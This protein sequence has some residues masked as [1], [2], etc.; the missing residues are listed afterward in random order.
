MENNI[1][2]ELTILKNY[3]V[4]K[5]GDR[6]GILT[7]TSYLGSF[8][9]ET[10]R[11]TIH[12]FSTVCD[13]GNEVLKNS[14]ALRSARVNTSCGCL[15]GVRHIV[16]PDKKIY[17]CWR[18]YK[19]SPLGISEEWRRSHKDF[20][21]G[22]KEMGWKK[23]MA[24][25]R[26]RFKDPL[27]RDNI[28]FAEDVKLIGEKRTLEDKLRNMTRP[29]SIQVGD[30]F[31]VMIVTK[32]LGN[33][34]RSKKFAGGKRKTIEEYMYKM[35][36][37]CGTEKETSYD[38]LRNSK[39][40]TS[41]GCIKRHYMVDE[42]TKFGSFEIIKYLGYRPVFKEEESTHVYL[43]RCVCGFYNE[44]DIYK[45]KDGYQPNCGCGG[46]TKTD[47]IKSLDRETRIKIFAIWRH[48]VQG[49]ETYDAWK[50]RDVFIKFALSKGWNKD[51]RFLRKYFLEPFSP[52]NYIITE[53]KNFSPLKERVPINNVFG[54][55][56]SIEES[57]SRIASYIESKSGVEMKKTIRFVKCRC[58]CGN[59]KDIAWKDLKSG[60]INSCGCKKGRRP[61]ETLYLLDFWEAN[62]HDMSEDFSSGYDNFKKYAKSQGWKKGWSIKKVISSQEYCKWNTSI[63]P[64]KNHNLTT[65]KE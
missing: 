18:Y 27:S 46:G 47:I 63:K 13:C 45:I 8:K 61:N 43:C 25:Q 7:I 3:G 55:L 50:D 15:K 49:R 62:R 2:E 64:P 26:L 31:G 44:R 48:N 39:D 29:P 5:I 28:L 6:F 32:L 19:K 40:F 52:N 65:E 33:V 57:G 17:A 23:G 42:G 37:Q 12:R 36:C 1:K 58:S 24:I 30:K 20:I 60:K 9:R 22:I 34:K 10:S 59:T 53:D 56:T 4:F 38:S 35:R 11:N 51:L 54:Y 21:K 41:C 16:D 14:D